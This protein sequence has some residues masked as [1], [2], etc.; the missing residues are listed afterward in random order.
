M[1]DE[2]STHLVCALMYASPIISTGVAWIKVMIMIS[3]V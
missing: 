3:G 2:M 1:L